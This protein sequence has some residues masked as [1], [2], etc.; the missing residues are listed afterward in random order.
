MPSKKRFPLPNTS[1][2][3]ERFKELAE[4]FTIDQLPEVRRKLAAAGHQLKRH[5]NDLLGPSIRRGTELLELCGFLLDSYD[6]RSRY[7]Q[8]MISGA[9]QYVLMRADAVDDA[10]PVVGFD[11]DTMIVNHVLEELR[12]ND[13]FLE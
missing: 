7:E 11:D 3:A 6:R 4:A 13:R 5:E 12:I 1:R 8:A 10:T 9:V 2:A